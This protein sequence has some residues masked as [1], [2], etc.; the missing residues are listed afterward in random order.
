MTPKSA[1][2]RPRKSKQRLSKQLILQTAM[3]I[4]QQDGIDALTFRGLAQRLD[5]TPMAITYHSGSKHALVA[6]LVRT[7]FKGTLTNVE[8]SDPRDLA[9]RILASYYARAL[10]HANLLRA[11]LDDVSLMSDELVQI[12]DELRQNAQALTNGDPGDVLLHLLIDYTHGFVL[13]ASAGK[14]NPLT[15]Q[16]YLRGVDWVLARASNECE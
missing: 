4:I 15:V 8:G 5:V 2:G 11:I 13:S 7:A 16:D 3:P 10:Q 1:A 12:T 9:R 6:D 14:N